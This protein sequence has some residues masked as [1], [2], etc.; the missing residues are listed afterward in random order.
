MR[1]STRK[2]R[3]EAV[4]PAEGRDSVCRVL[5]RVTNKIRAET[6]DKTRR[7]PQLTT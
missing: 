7:Q 4:G 5:T 2:L 1:P 3:T 6:K